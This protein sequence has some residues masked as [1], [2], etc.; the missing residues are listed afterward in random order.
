MILPE[1][2]WLMPQEYPDLRSYPEIAI[3][4]ETRDPELKSKGSGS[5]I[6]KGEIVGFAVAVEGYR[7]YFPIAHGRGS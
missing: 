1:T 4:L 2:E 3:D 7:G 6:G 5:V